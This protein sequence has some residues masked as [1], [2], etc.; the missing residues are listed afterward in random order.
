MFKKEML[1]LEWRLFEDSLN[2]KGIGNVFDKKSFPFLPILIP[3]ST[4]GISKL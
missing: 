2:V 4:E 3:N 1:L